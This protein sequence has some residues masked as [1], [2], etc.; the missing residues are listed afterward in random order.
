M[1]G[2]ATCF[3]RRF[4]YLFRE[5]VERGGREPHTVMPVLEIRCRARPLRQVVE[6]LG[7]GAGDGVLGAC[8]VVFGRSDRSIRVLGLDRRQQGCVHRVGVIGL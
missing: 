8:Q 3:D 6:Q 7:S 1:I 5:L 2:V 4:S